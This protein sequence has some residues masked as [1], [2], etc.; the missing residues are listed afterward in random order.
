MS[1]ARVRALAALLAFALT[2]PALSAEQAPRLQRATLTV[3][4]LD[5]SL[6][7]YRDLLGFTVRATMAYETPAMRTLFHLPEGANP[8]LTLLDAGEAQ[9]RALALVS[10]DGV[11][12]DRAANLR[13]APALVL[14][15]SDMDAIDAA[16]RGAGVEVLLPP[17]PLLDFSGKP[18]GREAAYV[19]P[20]GVRVVLFEQ[21]APA[22][23]AP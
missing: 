19:D 4:D 2:A 11:E 6:A 8:T 12:I 7:F 22:A 16:M 1:R 18:M 13:N 9:P 17:T 3:T 21:A 14:T 10:A 5:R 20:D 15:V 23:D